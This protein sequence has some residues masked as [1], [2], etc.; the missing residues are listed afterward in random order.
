MKDVGVV[1]VPKGNRLFSWIQVVFV[2]QVSLPAEEILRKHG[3]R[4]PN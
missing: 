2:A 1:E 3:L 4:T